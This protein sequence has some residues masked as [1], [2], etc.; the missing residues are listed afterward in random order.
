M[1]NENNAAFQPVLLQLFISA[2]R[3][4]TTLLDEQL[5]PLDL[6]AAKYFAL[7]ILADT[8]ERIA[9]S[10]L[11]D[12]MGTGKSNMTPLVDRL[13][14]DGMVRRVR[15]EQDRRVVFIEITA[16][17]RER[18]EQA[19]RLFDE[20][21]HRVEDSYSTAEIQMLTSLLTRFVMRFCPPH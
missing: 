21:S 17:G 18:L 1:M 20:L 10:T 5:L 15:S 11:A 12:R 6:S 7:Y 14:S 2:G 13:E 3:A 4:M 16:L 9:L 19:K 8:A